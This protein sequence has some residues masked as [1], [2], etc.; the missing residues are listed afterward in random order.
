MGAIMFKPKPEVLRHENGWLV[1]DETREQILWTTDYHTQKDI[2]SRIGKDY[3]DD[4]YNSR[5]SNDH[6]NK[7]TNMLLKFRKPEF[8]FN[9][10][11]TLLNLGPMKGK[12]LPEL[13]KTLR[14]TK[15][16]F[17]DI[18]S[19]WFSYLQKRVGN[20]GI[21]AECIIVGNKDPL[22]DIESNSIDYIWS[23]D[24]ITRAHR[25]EIERYFVSFRRILKPGG[26]GL[27]H[28]V[29]EYT[30]GECPRHIPGE[31]PMLGEVIGG[32][33]SISRSSVKTICNRIG[34][35]IMGLETPFHVGV[36]VVI[37]GSN[38]NQ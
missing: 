3:D 34:L 6:I 19:N 26:V 9:T 4:S 12:W 29:D 13:W 20:Y 7:I 31:K 36:F 22:N 11:T 2:Y 18:Q 37:E 16:V 35:N 23:A 14:P 5:E 28:I 27:I 24:A 25:A 15:V 38:E 32:G 17:A 1:R 30:P 8:M 33:Y 21:E 10:T